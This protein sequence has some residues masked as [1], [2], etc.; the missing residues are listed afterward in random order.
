MT[1][2]VKVPRELFAELVGDL[3]SE[4]EAHAAG[5]LPRRIKRDL[6]TVEEAERLLA[7]PPAQNEEPAPSEDE[8]VERAYA[9]ISTSWPDRSTIRNALTAAGFD[10]LRRERDEAVKFGDAAVKRMTEL[11]DEMGRQRLWKE[12]A[13]SE[14]DRLAAELAE[15]RKDAERYRWLRVC[16]KQYDDLPVLDHNGTLNAQF[17]DAAI[18]SAREAEEGK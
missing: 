6:Q 12:R 4:I 15:A 10:Q 17:L 8:G 13:E 11:E 9:V 14:R 18:D 5:E 7:T 3:R 2:F 16:G 1:D